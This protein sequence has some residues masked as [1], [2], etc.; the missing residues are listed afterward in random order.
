MDAP[1][2]PRPTSRS[3]SKCRAC[4]GFPVA[5]SCLPRS[6]ASPPKSPAKIDDT[7]R[8]LRSGLPGGTGTTDSDIMLAAME[9]TL[10]DGM[11]VVNQSIGSARQ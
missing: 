11:H 5:I 1:R 9:M 4:V 3:A 8:C 2:P 7:R 10:A 6:R